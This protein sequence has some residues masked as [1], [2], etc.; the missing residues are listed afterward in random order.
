MDDQMVAGRHH[1]VRVGVAGPN[2]IR[3]ISD[4][5]SRVFSRRLRQDLLI[6]QLRQLLLD[7]VHIQ[8]VCG[9]ID[10][11]FRDYLDI[12]II[13]HLEQRTSIPE[14]VQELLGET[15]PTEGPEPATDSTTHDNAIGIFHAICY[16]DYTW[17]NVAKL[18]DEG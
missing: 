5:R 9:D 12:T 11:F 17:T 15:F 8:S 3:G 7:E 4:A 13:G 2:V 18:S 1:D 6:C 10:M 14:K 16:S